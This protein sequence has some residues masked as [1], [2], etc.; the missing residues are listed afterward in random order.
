MTV[1]KKST[2]QLLYLYRRNAWLANPSRYIS[3]YSTHKIDRPIFLLGTQNGGLTLIS[4]MLRRNSSVISVTGNNSYW[5]GADE[6]QNILGPV[7]PKE[8]TGIK[9]K[10]P[11]DEIFGSPRE[12]IYAT[13]RLLPKYR[14][15]AADTTHETGQAL[16]KVI[17]ESIKR[18]GGGEA[19]RF[20]D[21]SQLYT[22]KVAFINALLRES[23]PY[24]ILV[25][26][27]P[28][29]VC[30]S[31][32]GGTPSLT[33]LSKSHDFNARLEL[34]AQHWNNSMKCALEDGHQIDNF[35]TIRFEGVLANPRG[36]LEEICEFTDLLFSEE[37]VPQ[38]HHQIPPGSTRKDR[39]YPVR[40]DVNDR[41]LSQISPDQ[42]EIVRKTCGELAG[43][44]G[45]EP[46]GSA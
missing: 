40:P 19:V 11:P 5:A 3:T 23:N 37:M 13:D 44:F 34:A 17:R 1:L 31:R 33:N 46:I 25:T 42:I 16:Q 4:R 29:A 35:M 45:Y 24:F 32:A 14:L 39:W 38:E 21:K 27:N 15:T 20:T 28:Y 10:V 12:W 18:H 6:M 2:D 7:L 36:R 8:L 41:S 43:Q 22:V 26:R 9:H 30:F